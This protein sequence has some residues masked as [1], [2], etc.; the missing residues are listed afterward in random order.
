MPECFSNSS[1]WLARASARPPLMSTSAARPRGVAGGELP[2]GKERLGEG[3]EGGQSGGLGKGVQ[4][5]W[6]SASAW[7]ARV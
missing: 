7:F 4:A 3:A 6:L 1:F 5:K 2:Q